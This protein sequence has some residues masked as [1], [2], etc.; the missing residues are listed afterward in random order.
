MVNRLGGKILKSVDVQRELLEKLK[1]DVEAAEAEG[2]MVVQ[3]DEACF[4]DGTHHR[5]HFAPIGD[6]IKVISFYANQGFRCVCAAIHPELGILW[7]QTI[8]CG[9][10]QWTID[11]FLR[12]LRSALPGKK[13]AVL[14]DNARIHHAHQVTK[15]GAP[16]CDIRIIWNVPY[17][18]DCMGV[19]YYWK[20][21]KARYYALRDAALA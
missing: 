6:P 5:R 20:V 14:L 15:V 13:I 8:N 17:R 4:T 2:Y 12:G 11:L 16:H 9:F 7:R 10:T 1:A 21:A 18:P 19:E 3:I